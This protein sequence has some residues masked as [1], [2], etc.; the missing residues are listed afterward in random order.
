MCIIYAC[1]SQLLGF[2]QFDLLRYG[3][4]WKKGVSG[5]V[6]GIEMRT[7]RACAS[8][9]L[10]R[11]WRRV[12]VEAHTAAIRIGSRYIDSCIGTSIFSW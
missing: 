11:N 7:S 3:R 10:V 5:L 4:F 9:L 8:A 6:I 1:G 2:R 12:N